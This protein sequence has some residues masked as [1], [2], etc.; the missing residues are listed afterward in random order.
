MVDPVCWSTFSKQGSWMSKRNYE[1][2]SCI[3]M[4]LTLLIEMSMFRNEWN[5]Y[6]Q[7]I[8]MSTNHYLIGSAVPS[9]SKLR[10][11]VSFQH[12]SRLLWQEMAM[13]WFRK[14]SE[15]GH[16]HS[17]YNLAVGHFTGIKTGRGFDAWSFDLWKWWVEEILKGFESWHGDGKR[18]PSSFS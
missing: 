16:P 13:V 3:P 6:E 18:P 14:A 7:D 11:L 1:M 15:Q 4:S 12:C 17:A 2:R 9:Y 8:E 10:W 5:K